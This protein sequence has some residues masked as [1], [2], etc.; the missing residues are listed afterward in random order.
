MII[1]MV[2][3]Q[4]WGSL[5]ITLSI[6]YNWFTLELQLFLC[7]NDVMDYELALKRGQTK[8]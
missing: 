6:K 2:T 8:P 4:L 3:Q 7:G 5:Q 1:T